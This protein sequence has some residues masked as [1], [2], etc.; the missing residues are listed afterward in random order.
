MPFVYGLLVGLGLGWVA[1]FFF[2]GFCDK[3]A[4]CG[5]CGRRCISNKGKALA[6]PKVPE[7]Y[8]CRGVEGSVDEY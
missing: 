7:Y 4:S 1:V 2:R 3:C 5:L 8:N 6:V